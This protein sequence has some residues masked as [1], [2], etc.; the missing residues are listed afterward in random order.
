MNYKSFFKDQKGFS[1]TPHKNPILSENL[2]G[3]REWLEEGSPCLENIALW[4]ERDISHW[5]E[6]Y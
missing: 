4:H 6:K 1:A 5:R 2:T 3:L